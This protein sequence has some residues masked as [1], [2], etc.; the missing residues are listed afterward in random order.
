MAN[1]GKI[2]SPQPE[3]EEARA[4]ILQYLK[5]NTKKVAPV[6]FRELAEHIGCSTSVIS[7]HL[8]RL[9]REG[10]IKRENN[11]ARMIEV[12]Q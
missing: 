9:E 12:V 3:G 8:E 4:K 5:K 10:K 7:Y 11:V 6:S 1:K 2:I